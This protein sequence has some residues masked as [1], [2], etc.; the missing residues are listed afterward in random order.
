[1][2][3]GQPPA[4]TREQGAR[5]SAPGARD[6]APGTGEQAPAAGGQ[7]PGLSG[8]DPIRAQ[9]RARIALAALLLVLTGAG[10]RAADPL[11]I[12][13]GPLHRYGRPLGLAVELALLALLI[14]VSRLRARSRD[15]TH[16]AFLLNSMLRTVIGI[17][18]VALPAAAL[19]NSVRPV[20]IK[21]LKTQATGRGHPKL[22]KPVKQPSASAGHT[23]IVITGWLLLAA[24]LAAIVLCAV[25]IWRWRRRPAQTAVFDPP[26][27]DEFAAELRRAVESGRRA[28]GEIDDARAAIIACYV[29]MEASLAEAGTVRTAAETPDELLARAVSGQLVSGGAAGQLTALFYQARFSAR[30]LPPAHRTAAQQALVALAAQLGGMLDA[31]LKAAAGATA[32]T[33]TG[34]QAGP[35]GTGS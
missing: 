13:H 18:L 27:D 17:G 22:P 26:P 23:A 7:A 8:P 24:L 21:P 30:P 34:T 28:L 3:H 12:G 4:D 2:T 31:E 10:I 20:H 14:A 5:V 33:G 19:L 1:M 25:L 35:A 6:Q 9:R 29:A 32:S 15:A 11:V 16:V